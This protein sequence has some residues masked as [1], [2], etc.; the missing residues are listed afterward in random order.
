MLDGARQSR[1]AAPTT[2]DKWEST[3]KHR[4][5]IYL[6]TLCGILSVAAAANWPQ[7]R[8]P[9]RDGISN[10]TGLLQE[11]PAEGPKLLWQKDDLGDGYSTPSIVGERVFLINN[12]GN[13]NEFVQCLSV[14]D[15][16]PIW[17]TH[18]GKVGKPDQQPSVP[19]ERRSPAASG[20]F[21]AAG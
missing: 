20:L 11:W 12:K 6:F 7:W 10:E 1:F 19:A 15:G 2:L 5:V 3:M 4:R 18:I 16:S 21:A 9:N 8:G 17:Q 13:D 14:K